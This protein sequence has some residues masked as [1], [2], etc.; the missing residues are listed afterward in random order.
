MTS[1][2]E[3]TWETVRIKD[4]PSPGFEE[5][6]LLYAE[7]VGEEYVHFEIDENGQSV[8][9]STAEDL[10]SYIEKVRGIMGRPSDDKKLSSLA[11]FNDGTKF[12]D[13]PEKVEA[14]VLQRPDEV[15][16]YEGGYEDCVIV[17][18]RPKVK[19]KDG[20]IAH[21]EAVIHGE[22]VGRE[23]LLALL[24]R[25]ATSRVVEAIES[26]ESPIVSRIVA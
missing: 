25:T 10:V 13:T 11:R 6:D 1:H 19:M 21:S 23:R 24:S 4:E 5:M 16:V 3:I 8:M 18:T 17:W 22:N 20:S 7:F 15:A 14:E 9:W 12:E 26:D 2:T